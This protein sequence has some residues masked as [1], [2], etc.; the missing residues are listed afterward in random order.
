VLSDAIALLE[1]HPG[2]LVEVIHNHLARPRNR[3]AA[4]VVELEKEIYGRRY[5]ADA[6]H[7]P[8]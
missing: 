3:T 7:A 1:A 4:D 2:R 6:S 8:G 5:V